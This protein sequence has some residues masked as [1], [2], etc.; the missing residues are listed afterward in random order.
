MG[1]ATVQ[2]DAAGEAALAAAPGDAITIGFR[3]ESLRV[4]G[5]P[6]QGR[7]RTVEDLGSEVFVHV[8]VDHM[9]KNLPL[10]AKMAA[11]FAGRPGDNVGLSLAG[12]THI[13]GA[14]DLRLASPSAGLLA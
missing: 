13:F 1:N 2:F 6:L 3:P 12:T 11:P 14:G 4:D 9:G 7:I 10:V 8:G 5:G